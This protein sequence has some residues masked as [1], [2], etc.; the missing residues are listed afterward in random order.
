MAKLLQA[1]KDVYSDLPTM[2]RVVVTQAIHESGF[3]NGGSVLA[4]R[5]N[6]LF[7]IKGK[8]AVLNTIE[9]I[10][11]VRT[12]VKAEFA[13]YASIE[14]CFKAHRRL[15]ECGVSW[16]RSLYV[17]VISANT[18]SAAFDALYKCG[19]ATDPKYPSKLLGIYNQY[20]SKVF[21]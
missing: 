18:P 6:N 3:L 19:Y 5:Y 16:N 1:A 8:G 9:Y 4:N 13:A 7:G 14:D 15:M 11:G 17:P 10:K 20:V 12:Q 2:Q 21:N